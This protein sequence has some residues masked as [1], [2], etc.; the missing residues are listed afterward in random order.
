MIDG[1]PAALRRLGEQDKAL[2]SVSRTVS[3]EPP[4]DPPMLM[5]LQLSDVHVGAEDNRPHHRRLAAAVALANALRPAFVI[6]T[7]DV[8]THPVY[9]ARPEHLAELAEYGRY[10]SALDMPL[11]VVPG[12]HDIG[13]F[14]PGDNTTWGDGQLWADSDELEPVFEQEIGPLDQAFESHGFRF[15][16]VNNNP[17]VTKG[18]GALSPSQL[19][20]LAGEL[21]KGQTTFVFCHVELL[22]QGTGPLWGEA[23]NSVAAL[24]REHGVPA[25]SYGH[26]H[27]L[28]L[29]KRDRTLYIMCPDLKVPGHDEVL[30]Y[31]LWL[32]HFDLW[33]LN[34]FS[35]EGDHLG[36]YPFPA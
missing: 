31:R 32:D 8:A 20:F 2:A 21:M 7:G 16:L 10:V 30:Q 11:H 22:E 35:G 13:Y 14:E 36:T 4:D 6:D 15:V 23:A 33:R 12:N 5:F 29:V 9:A 17:A 34:V 3:S 27:R 1:V 18:P 24:C 19:Q 26:R 28:H 25:V